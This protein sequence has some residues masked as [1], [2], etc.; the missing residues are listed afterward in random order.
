MLND[1]QKSAINKENVETTAGADL[2]NAD[3][4]FEEVVGADFSNGD[5][6][7]EQAT[8]VEES[9]G[10]INPPEEPHPPL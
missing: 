2:P 10:E 1:A 6:A 7:H 5:E 4:I 9:T 8:Q 3:E